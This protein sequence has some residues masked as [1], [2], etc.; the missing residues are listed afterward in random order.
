MRKER[1]RTAYLI[2][3]MWPKNVVI[4]C[5][6]EHPAPSRS[7]TQHSSL[8]KAA[9]VSMQAVDS[10]ERKVSLGFGAGVISINK[11]PASKGGFFKS[12][13]R[14]AFLALREVFFMVFFFITFFFFIVFAKNGVSFF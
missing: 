13:Y 14:F 6:N 3:P 5:H 4:G 1:V 10:T 11:K 12:Y 7:T 8:M 2:L 9:G